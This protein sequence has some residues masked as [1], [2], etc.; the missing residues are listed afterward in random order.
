MPG[1]SPIDSRPTFGDATPKRCREKTEPICANCTSQSA[2][3]SALAPASSS[4]VGAMPG[5]GM[6]VAIAGRL[7]PLMRPIRSSAD[8]IVAPVL[9]AE[10]I[11]E[12]W[13]SRTASAARTSVESFLRRTARPPSSSISMTSLATMSGRSP[14]STRSAR[15]AGPTSTIGVPC[16][17]AACAPAMIAPGAWS[18]PIAST[19]MGSMSRRFSGSADVDGDAVLVPTARRA[20]RVRGLRVAAARAGAPSGR[21]QL[22]RTSAVA[23]ALHLRL[24]LLRNGHGGSPGSEL[25]MSRLAG[26]PSGRTKRA[27]PG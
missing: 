10:I 26:P 3:T 20:D 21:S 23:A 16:A 8:A 27:A 6:M 5:T 19:A 25:R 7:T 18:P 14:M 1:S 15:S 11:A 9:P 2:C 24:L 17:A 4:T 12:A 22:P 13:P